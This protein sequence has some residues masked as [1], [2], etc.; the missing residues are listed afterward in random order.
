MTVEILNPQDPQG[1]LR[2]ADLGSFPDDPGSN[3][4]Y[5]LTRNGPSSAVDTVTITKD[6]VS[7]VKTLTYTGANLTGVSAWV[8]Q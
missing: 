2:V 4:S 1:A 6:G 5:A 8:R 7:W 3:Y